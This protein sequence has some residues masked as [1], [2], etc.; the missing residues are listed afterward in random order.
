MSCSTVTVWRSPFAESI[1]APPRQLKLSVCR[2]S[3]R[4]RRGRTACD[5]VGARTC[6]P[7]W[8]QAGVGPRWAAGELQGRRH[9]ERNR[10]IRSGPTPSGRRW[11]CSSQVVGRP[12]ARDRP[13][14]A[15]MVA[16][17]ANGHGAGEASGN[18][19]VAARTTA[20]RDRRGL[21]RSWS[22]ASGHWRERTDAN[23]QKDGHHHPATAWRIMVSHSPP[24]GPARIQIRFTSTRRARRHQYGRSDGAVLASASHWLRVRRRQCH[25]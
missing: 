9:Q 25:S 23:R 4:C 11:P 21:G 24:P 22:P 5:D 7:D 19:E 18:G 6:R 1:P 17:A 10:A 13:A 16:V 12:G 3:P 8:S 15:L 20:P 14:T 2:P